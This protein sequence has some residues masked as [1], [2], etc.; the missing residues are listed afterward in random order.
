MVLLL[1]S[2]SYVFRPSTVEEASIKKSTQNLKGLESF[3]F[4]KNVVIFT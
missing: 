1:S 3:I 4:L 2:K